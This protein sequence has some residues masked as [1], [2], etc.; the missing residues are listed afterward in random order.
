MAPGF[1]GSVPRQTDWL[2]PSRSKNPF[3][4]SEKKPVAESVPLGDFL[5]FSDADVSPSLCCLPPHP[6][7]RWSDRWRDCSASPRTNPVHAH[8]QF[9]CERCFSNGKNFHTGICAALSSLCVSTVRI[10]AGWRFGQWHR[11]WIIRQLDGVGRSAAFLLLFCDGC[12]R[13]RPY[14]FSH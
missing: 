4:A 10:H 8:A 2:R 7:G 6:F 5:G 3:S 1:T 12:C 14:G 11:D 9:A 13:L